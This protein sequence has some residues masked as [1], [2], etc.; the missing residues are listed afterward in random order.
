MILT[1]TIIKHFLLKIY[2][3]ANFVIVIS[4]AKVKIAIKTELVSFSIIAIHYR[5]HAI[6]QLFRFVA[7]ELI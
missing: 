6:K 3:Q 5:N 4:S 1:C 7:I 2:V